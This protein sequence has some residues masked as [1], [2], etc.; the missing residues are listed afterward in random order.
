MEGHPRLSSSTPNRDDVVTH[1]SYLMEETRPTT[2]STTV[3]PD[4]DDGH[5]A[6][7]T[8]LP[9]VFDDI[10]DRVAEERRSQR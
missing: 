4:V 1:A 10:V 8:S 2:T 9:S 5:L 7:R 3:S 6:Q